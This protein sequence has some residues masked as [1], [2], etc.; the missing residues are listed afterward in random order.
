MKLLQ[1]IK[2]ILTTQN[3]L[4]HTVQMKLATKFVWNTKQTDFLTHTVQ[5]KLTN[6]VLNQP[7][8]SMFLTH[9]VQMKQFIFSDYTSSFCVLNPHG[10]DETHETKN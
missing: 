2:V 1:N 5:M 7:I 4:T 10:S 8:V 6:M 3:F 9:T